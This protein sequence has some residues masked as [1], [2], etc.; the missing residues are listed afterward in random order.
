ML[1]RNSEDAH[2]VVDNLCGLN[3]GLT[4]QL[5]FMKGKLVV[6]RK[7]QGPPAVEKA[8]NSY[9]KVAQKITEINESR[10]INI[11]KRPLAVIIRPKVKEKFNSSDEVKTALQNTYRSSKNNVRFKII[12]NRNENI[13][14]E[15]DTVESLEKLKN[16]AEIQK[17]FEVQE[18]TKNKPKIIVYNVSN[19]VSE[20]KLTKLIFEKKKN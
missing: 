14:E 8:E 20:R 19:K 15:T 4:A 3:A 6:Y 12:V 16:S 7:L 5:A 18:V 1:K 11:S 9:N 17:K 2:D 13:L 10:K